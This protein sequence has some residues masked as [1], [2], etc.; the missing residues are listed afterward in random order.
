MLLV[1]VRG[2]PWPRSRAVRLSTAQRRRSWAWW[3]VVV[4]A[5][6]TMGAYVLFDIL[7]V[8]GSQM[9][10]WPADAII[11]AEALQIEADRCFRPDTL[12]PD[13]P[14]LLALPLARW[15]ATEQHGLS[16]DTIPL[17]VRH[18]RMLPRV[19]LH[20]ALAQTSTLSADPV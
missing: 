7:D 17:R 20:Q 16:P 12:T 10:G 9:T 19:N 2:N 18:R 1:Q 15:S 4:V 14:G 6:L 5:L 13:A 11:V 3:S 8:D